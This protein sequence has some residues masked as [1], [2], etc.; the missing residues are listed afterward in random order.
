MVDEEIDPEEIPSPE[1]A[2]AMMRAIGGR[3]KVLVMVMVFYILGLRMGEAC[4]LNVSDWKPKAGYLRVAKSGHDDNDTKGHAPMRHVEVQPSL[5]PLIDKHIA[6]YCKGPDDPLFPGP[7]GGRLTGSNVRQRYFYPAVD[8]ALGQSG[9]DTEKRRR[10]R[11]HDLRHT[12]ATI[13]I[14]DGVPRHRDRKTART[15]RLIVHPSRVCRGVAAS[16]TARQRTH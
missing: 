11:P 16:G 13:M 14:V 9:K 6:K 15:F 2:R 3:F 1:E 10:I 4:A 12:A 8:M 5:A 7:R